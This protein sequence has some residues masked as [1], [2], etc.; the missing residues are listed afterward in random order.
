V[1]AARTL[2]CNKLNNY[3][4]SR[5]ACAACVTIDIL[6]L[7]KLNGKGF[8]A[9]RPIVCDFA[10]TYLDVYAI[11]DASYTLHQLCVRNSHT[12]CSNVR[13]VARLHGIAT[14][15]TVRMCVCECDVI[16]HLWR[17]QACRDG[18]IPLLLRAKHGL[19]RRRCGYCRAYSD[20]EHKKPGGARHCC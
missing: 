1:P 6:V 15:K 2:C 11:T 17:E 20:D 7:A 3:W 19:G 12:A 5:R 4:R 9:R 10:W 18:V 8:C 14:A 16:A 13:R